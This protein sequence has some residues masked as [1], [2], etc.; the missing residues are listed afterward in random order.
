MSDILKIFSCSVSITSL[1]GTNT[2][3]T[4]VHS[5][6]YKNNIDTI[7]ATCEIQCPLYVFV[8]MTEDSTKKIPQPIRNVFKQGDKISVFYGYN[9]QETIN[10]FNGYIYMFKDGQPSTMICEDER[11]NLRK[12]ILNKIWNSSVNLSDIVKYIVSGT[13]LITNNTLGVSGDIKYDSFSIKNLSP[14]T[15]LE[16][17]KNKLG[18]I[19]SIVQNQIII[20][21]ASIGLKEHYA[22]SSDKNCFYGTDIQQQEGIWQQFTIKVNTV[23][24]EGKKEVFYIS[25]NVNKGQTTYET[26]NVVK[27]EGQMKQIYTMRVSKSQSEILAKNAMLKYQLGEYTGKI[28]GLIYPNTEIL[29]L[30]DYTDITFPNRNGVYFI[31]SKN[32]TITPEDGAKQILEVGQV[33]I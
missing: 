29:G 10:I 2:V 30:L 15:A 26:S 24:E 1:D 18:I 33:N 14:L 5:I 8:P 23:N 20:T 32:V 6:D 4:Q 21:F 12:G 3:L 17:I 27:G 19:I 25:N 7:G 16:D 13:S 31:K 22:F 9:N 11:F 28:V